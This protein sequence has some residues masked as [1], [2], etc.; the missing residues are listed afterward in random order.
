MT[1]T[2]EQM[3]DRADEVKAVSHREMV[4]RSL[5]QTAR[6]AEALDGPIAE[7]KRDLA[8]LNAAVERAQEARK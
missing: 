4:A 7:W 6:D 2:P 8:E 3:L 5:L 1:L